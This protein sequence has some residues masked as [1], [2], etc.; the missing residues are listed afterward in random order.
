MGKLFTVDRARVYAM[1]FSALGGL[2]AGGVMSHALG[3]AAANT[4][5][6]IAAIDGPF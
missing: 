5:A 4:F 2:S 3:C 6:A 1:G